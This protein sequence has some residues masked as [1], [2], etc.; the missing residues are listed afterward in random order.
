[1]EGVR[2]RLKYNIIRKR[3]NLLLAEGFTE[4]A[5]VNKEMKPV[6]FRKKFKEI[7][8]M[9]KKRKMKRSVKQ[10]YIIYSE[11]EE[12]KIYE[13]RNCKKNSILFPKELP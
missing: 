1:M 13:T 5:F 7:W 2:L 8:D 9:L 6:N 10:L 4:H 12:L 3:D 11:R